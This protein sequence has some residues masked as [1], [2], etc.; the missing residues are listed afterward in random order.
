MKVRFRFFL[1][2]QTAFILQRIIYTVGI[3]LLK[4]YFNFNLR[5]L[6]KGDFLLET[7]ENRHN[8]NYRSSTRIHGVK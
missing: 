4:S 6:K 7:N 1:A 8:F 5:N 3:I 2:G